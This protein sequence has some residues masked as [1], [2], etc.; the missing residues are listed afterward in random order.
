MKQS[1]TWVT[2]EWVTL[3]TQHIFDVDKLITWQR[4][5]EHSVEVRKCVKAR[6]SFKLPTACGQFVS[7]STIAYKQIQYSGGEDWIDSCTLVT[8]KIQAILLY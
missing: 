7:P 2:V 3:R 6:L 5:I 4:I 8:R 1:V